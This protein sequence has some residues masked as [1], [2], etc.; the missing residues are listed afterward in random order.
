MPKIPNEKFK[1]KGKDKG[2]EKSRGK[3]E[4]TGSWWP[5]LW[6]HTWIE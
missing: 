5:M 6:G 4:E 3:P 1:D 2:R